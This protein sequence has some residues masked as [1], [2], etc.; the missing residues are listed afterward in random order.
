MKP[1]ALAALLCAAFAGSAA[2]QSSV[3]VYGRINTTVEYQD[4]GDDKVTSVENNNS[5][6]GLR[7]KEDLG[8][9]LNTFFM[10]EQGFRSDDGG[11]SGGFNREAWA[12]LHS[13]QY[14]QL[15]IGRITSALYYATLDYIGVFNHDTG[16]TA[17]DKFWVLNFTS[18]NAVEYTSPK[19]GGFA[20]ALTASAG[21]G[22]DGVGTNSGVD[23]ALVYSKTYEGVVTYDVDNLHIGAGYSQS[24]N[25]ADDTVVEGF[26]AAGFYTFGNFGVGLA[27]QHNDSD[28]LG[29]RDSVTATGMYTLGSGEFHV[30]LGWADDWDDV[31]DSAATSWLLGYNYNLSK[32]TKVYAF[33]QAVDND[34]NATYGQ[35]YSQTAVLP[36]ETW[37]TVGVGIR[38]AF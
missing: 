7:G 9:G 18:P 33:Y 29:K 6:W 13:S 36:D 35:G 24:R 19:F 16:T 32:R 23:E 38:H 15:K 21:E 25:V 27:Y 3:T 17:E 14:G 34:K 4:N 10:L 5:R 31:K 2:A 28:L 22:N 12:G 1:I 37:Q 11:G 30:A 26:A 20:V 8:G